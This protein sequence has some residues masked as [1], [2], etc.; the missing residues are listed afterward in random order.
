[1]KIKF[2]HPLLKTKSS[3]EILCLTTVFISLSFNLQAQQ[4]VRWE[5]D[6]FS[7]KPSYIELLRIKGSSLNA[8]GMQ[9]KYVT[10][11]VIEQGKDKSDKER[12]QLIEEDLKELTSELSILKSDETSGNKVSALEEELNALKESSSV[13]ETELK[14]L[15]DQLVVLQA[16]NMDS[17][18]FV[19]KLF[20]LAEGLRRIDTITDVTKRTNEFLEFVAIDTAKYGSVKQAIG[21]IKELDVNEDDDQRRKDLSAI[22]S[23]KSISEDSTLRKVLLKIQLKE[24]ENEEELGR[25]DF[26]R[27]TILYRSVWEQKASSDDDA[28]KTKDG[29]ESKERIVFDSVSWVN[30]G[31]QQEFV[32]NLTKRLNFATTYSFEFTFYYPSTTD[33]QLDLIFTALYKELYDQLVNDNSISFADRDKVIDSKIALVKKEFENLKNYEKEEG[34]GLKEKNIDL[35]I[36]DDFG[37]KLKRNFLDLVATNGEK[38]NAEI[39]ISTSKE[40]LLG[41]IQAELNAGVASAD[42]KALIDFISAPGMDDTAIVALI[43]SGSFTVANRPALKADVKL[44]SDGYEQKSLSEN[45]MKEIEQTII[46][47]KTATVNYLTKSTQSSKI[48]AMKRVEE[49]EIVGERIGTAF[50]VGLVFFEIDNNDGLIADMFQSFGLKFY[51]KPFDKRLEDPYSFKKEE[52]TKFSLKRAWS[53]SSLLVGIVTSPRLVYE[54]QELIATSIG[55]KPLVGINYDVTKQFSVGVGSVFF[56]QPTPSTLSDRSSLVARPY[57]NLNFDFNVINYL[58]QKNQSN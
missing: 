50:G 38:D 25:G 32:L 2:L 1:M 4:E 13:R 55:V 52:G 42:V 36:V 8:K 7:A 26:S 24:S 35:S 39:N 14:T 46:Q 3:I 31:D 53:K 27:K 56:N 20:V 48:E 23:E 51:F 41:T 54:G 58:I 10:L 5:G 28:D 16:A 33:V 22:W 15:K 47:D 49:V 11:L 44:L 19:N 34:L 9:A 40:N 21:R 37:E 30:S 43:N 6:K 18:Q 57:V 45:K 12:I 17:V 29:N